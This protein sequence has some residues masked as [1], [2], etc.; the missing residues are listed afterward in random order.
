M[1]ESEQ[2]L[3]NHRR[4]GQTNRTNNHAVKKNV[5]INVSMNNFK[6]RRKFLATIFLILVLLPDP[7]AAGAGGGGG[8]NVIINRHSCF[9]KGDFEFVHV[10]YYIENSCTD[11]WI[12]R[13]V[14]YMHNENWFF[15][16][17]IPFYM[18]YLFCHAPVNA[19]FAQWPRL[20]LAS[21][22]QLT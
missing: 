19:T 3:L 16:R 15:R 6:M 14:E 9:F 5:P 4:I 22:T 8:H 18:V 13:K 7:E 11:F 20:P 10:F 21:Q 2:V 12:C 17:A 1:W